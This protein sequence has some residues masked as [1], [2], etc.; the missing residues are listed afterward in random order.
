MA[1]D[2]IFAL[3]LLPVFGAWSDRCKQQAWK[4]YSVYTGGNDSFGRLYADTSCG[5]KR[6]QSDVVHSD[7]AGDS[8]IHEHIS[9]SC[10]F[11]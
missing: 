11:S 6:T 4:T 3:I 10:G 5:G 2:N 1:L 9:F 7:T 8:D